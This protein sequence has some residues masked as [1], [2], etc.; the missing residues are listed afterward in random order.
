MPSIQGSDFYSVWN[1]I[2]SPSIVA[3]MRS[4]ALMVPSSISMDS[5]FS[6][7]CWI[8]RFIRLLPV[9]SAT[10]RSD[11]AMARPEPIRVDSVE[12]KRAT[13][14]LYRG[15]FS[16]G[17]RLTWTSIQRHTT[18]K[19][20]TLWQTNER[21]TDYKA[22]GIKLKQRFACNARRQFADRRTETQ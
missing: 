22:R 11:S 19:G 9:V 12:A 17:D 7:Y 16:G 1:T 18:L 5:G 10:T 6:I 14:L 21:T 3:V 2:W 8:A 13:T 4:P 15:C 20:L